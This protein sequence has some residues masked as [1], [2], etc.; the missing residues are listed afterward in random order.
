[1]V[2]ERRNGLF[3]Q[4]WNGGSAPQGRETGL[5]GKSTSLTAGL[6]GKVHSLSVHFH[7]EQKQTG[8]DNSCSSF[9]A[10]ISSDFVYIIKG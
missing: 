8:P 2:K 1:M 3:M 6:W 10:L 5:R 9:P 4:E 7:L